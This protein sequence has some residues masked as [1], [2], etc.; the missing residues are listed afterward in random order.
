MHMIYNPADGAP[1]SYQESPPASGSWTVIP[2]SAMQDPP[3]C[4]WDEAAQSWMEGDIGN[5]WN[6]ITTSFD[7]ALGDLQLAYFER[8]DRERSAAIAGVFPDA[9]TVAFTERLG[10]EAR[11]YAVDAAPD[12]ANY[13]MIAQLKTV[14][15]MSEAQ[16]VEEAR[17][18]FLFYQGALGAVWARWRKA[19]A[20]IDAA[21]TLAA[22]E[23]AVAI[24]WAA[25]I[26]GAADAP[27]TW[28]ASYLSSGA[29]GGG[30]T[31][32][33]KVAAQIDFGAGDGYAEVTVAA[34]WA[35]TALAYSVTPAL[36]TTSDHDPEDALLEGLTA[37][38]I[39]VTPGTS[40]T[41]GAHAPHG[42]WGRFDFN[43]LG[44]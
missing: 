7:F 33:R 25:V 1:I 20:D 40:L 37:S 27:P 36:P 13:P 12:L 44:V 23:A 21:T 42:T 8:I 17:S 39:A 4:Y 38:V 9:A 22:L 41:I 24:D 30:G 14:N 6:P 35:S 11:A 3:L 19:R 32:V 10:L 34:T 26:T 31:T 43:V 5:R 28:P 2:A 15:A 16:A 18:Q 29:G